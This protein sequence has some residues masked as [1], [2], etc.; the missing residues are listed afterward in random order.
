MFN[1]IIIGYIIGSYLTVSIV[2]I[3]E[4]IKFNYSWYNVIISILLSPITYIYLI[5]ITWFKNEMS[6]MRSKKFKGY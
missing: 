1:Q 3:Y 2:S 6:K 5:K 4:K